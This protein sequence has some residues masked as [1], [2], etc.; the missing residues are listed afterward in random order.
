LK[1][2]TALGLRRTSELSELNNEMPEI[3]DSA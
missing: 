1:E 3:F 2:M